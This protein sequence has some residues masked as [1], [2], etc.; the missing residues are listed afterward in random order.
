MKPS[1]SN[2]LKASTLSILPPKDTTH[3]YCNKQGTYTTTVHTTHSITP[4]FGPFLQVLS[5]E[6]AT[7]LLKSGRN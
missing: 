5:H 1:E 4:Q 6:A 2:K 7:T 3:P